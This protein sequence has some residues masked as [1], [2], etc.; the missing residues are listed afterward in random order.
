MGILV[1]KTNE[2]ARKIKK[3]CVFSVWPVSQ[4]LT[5]EIHTVFK[6]GLLK[7]AVL[8]YINDIF[9]AATNATAL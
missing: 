9:L 4:N 1:F 5:V 8:E 3:N 2:K 6:C 7:D